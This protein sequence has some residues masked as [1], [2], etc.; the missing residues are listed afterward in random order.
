MR[1]GVLVSL[2]CAALLSVACSTEA[3]PTRTPD[4]K[5]SAKAGSNVVW[6]LADGLRFDE[7]QSLESFREFAK[8][9]TVY[10]QATATASDCVPSIASMFTGLLPSEHGAHRVRLTRNGKQNY[11][12]K[13]LSLA[14]L[15]LAETLRDLGYETVFVTANLRLADESLGLTQGFD[16]LLLCAGSADLVNNRVESWLAQRGD[17]PF[18]L[19]IDYSDTRLGYATPPGVAKPEIGSQRDA[20]RL[21][22]KLDPAI[23]GGTEFDA[24][25][26][27]LLK[28]RYREGTLSLDFGVQSLFASLRA[29]GLYDDA[30][31]ILSSDHG[32]SLGEHNLLRHDRG[33]FEE[34]LHVPLAL[35]AP[36][37]TVPARVRDR[38]S[39]LRLPAEILR[40]ACPNADE[41]L[42]DPF[43]THG[44]K[45]DSTAEQ[46][47]AAPSDFGKP[48]S[49]RFDQV[50]RV[51]YRG[52]WKFIDS[53][54]GTDQLYDL[55]SD[56]RELDNLTE[57]HAGVSADMQMR[58]KQVF[59][60]L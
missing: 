29:R 2:G 21:A 39:L 40:Q 22:D 14:R 27:A 20:H 10:E 55:G 56:P 28:E 58:I 3:E 6:I 44:D 7:S 25:E 46:W 16:Q 60:E 30:L 12:E 4:S 31:V 32:E 8:H 51:H 43:A 24:A 5:G 18:V 23:L 35:K 50:L 48:W 57:R 34:S 59:G 41:N 11:H 19:V 37:Q 45:T 49:D 33:V 54:E 47:Y 38:F 53:D 15:T 13:P 36:R 9:A 1:G 17:R 42:H 52:R 26:L